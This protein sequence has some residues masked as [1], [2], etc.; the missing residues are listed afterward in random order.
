MLT[1]LAIGLAV[2]VVLR[3]PGFIL[4]GIIAAAAWTG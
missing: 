3:N 4:L 1:P 2:S